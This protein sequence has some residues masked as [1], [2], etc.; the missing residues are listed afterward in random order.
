MRMSFLRSAVV[1]LL[2]G[3][4]PAAA[5]TVIVV[6]P[7]AP[8]LV[9][10]AAREVRRYTY[11]RT[12]ALLPIEAAPVSGRSVIRLQRDAGLAEQ[13]YRLVTGTDDL[14]R[15]TLTLA[16]GSDHALLYAAYHF[17]ETLGVRFYLHGDV[18]PD[19]RIPFVWPEID[20]THTPLFEHRGLL[21]F[22]DFT[23]GPDWWEADDY[24]AYFNQ[25]A[26][27]RMNLMGL[28]C[29]PE[30]PHGPEPLVWIGHPDDVEQDGSVT[31][32]YP[33]FWNSTMG[34]AWGYAPTPTSSF[35]AGA[36]LLFEV[37]D[38]GP[39]VT[40]GHRP[41]PATPEAS[42]AVFNQTADLLND[43]FRY[44]RRLGMEVALGTETPLQIPREVQARLRER[45]LD[46]EDESVRQTVYE[47][48]FTRIARAYPIDYYWLWTPESWTWNPPPASAIA[49]AARDIELA[50]DALAKVGH[51]FRF[52][53][54]GWELGPP[55]D[56]GLFDRLLPPDA[57]MGSINRNI[58]FNWVD[59]EFVRIRNR[60]KWAIPWLEDDGAMVLPQLWAGRIRRDAADA[61]SYGCTGL[62][63]IHWR[64]KILAPNVAALAQAAWSQD[65]WNPEVD[66]R[67][68]LPE[69]PDTDVRLGG[70]NAVSDAP[71]EGTEEDAVYQ[72]CRY[73]VSG[74]RLAVPN[75]TYEVTL[76]FCEI[77]HT[78]P[79]RRVFGVSVQGERLMDQ[80]D[81]VAIAGRHVAHDRTAQG[82]R[83]E[84]EELVIDFHTVTEYPLI[85]AIVIDGQTDAVMQ[86]E[87]RPYT[88]RI[89]CGG[90]EWMDYDR[91]LE[92][93]GELPPLPERTRDLAVDDFYRAMCAAWFGPEVADEMADFFIRFDGD[94][95]AYGVQQGRA[96]LPRPITWLYGPGAIVADRTP[97]AEASQAYAFVDELAALRDRVTSPGDVGRFD[98]WWNSF[99]YLR[100]LAEAACARGALDI[101]MERAAAAE[102]ERRSELARDEAMPARVA[103]A[104]AWEDMM[105]QLLAVTDTPGGLGTVANLEQS[106]RTALQ[107]VSGHDERLS[108]WL[109][110]PL[111]EAAAVSTRYAGAPRIIVPTQRTVLDEGESVTLKVLVLDHEPP[112]EAALF[113]R[114]LG[115]E[116]FQRRP[117]RH[118]AR[119]VYEV[120]LPEVPAGG[121]EYHV[122]ATTASGDELVWPATAPALNHTL[123]QKPR[124]KE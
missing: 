75:G 110:G 15:R 70:M 123:V 102:G 89:N 120:V 93:A 36:G 28:H 105:T 13:A 14:G 104:R 41:L 50:R 111:D 91:D 47:G 19:R 86:F 52:G 30:G 103:L 112:A 2:A 99:R 115:E 1:G 45:G 31:F 108:E 11:V 60:P 98:Y 88:R 73:G 117:L 116:S 83:V 53:T 39:S 3:A 33:S 42:N 20:E 23:M 34:S 40:D 109:G 16:G 95:G 35:A 8:A 63:G 29:Y 76:K 101:A 113:W 71:V 118:V 121:A 64:T 90:E 79:G 94:G 24:K 22:H 9:Q 107:F 4:F 10:L 80:L 46:P 26:K 49:A 119:A 124:D 6:D 84:N 122:H 82:V 37:D 66:V 51:P 97:W 106:S 21:P 96:T 12:G 7:E 55:S 38:Y 57:V 85:S 25:M 81:L 27:L 67:M 74:Y 43:V 56:R 59:R 17:A 18:V 100:A 44:A 54:C 69:G 78:E 5:D 32:S 68:E 58:G 87:S 61:L 114:S 72:T 77:A 65:D 62:L 92:A 48:L